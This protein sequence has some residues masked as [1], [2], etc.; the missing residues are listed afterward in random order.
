M[1]TLRDLLRRARAKL[2]KATCSALA[3]VTT[4]LSGHILATIIAG[5]VRAPHEFCSARVNSRVVRAVS[6]I[7]LAKPSVPQRSE[8]QLEERHGSN[9]SQSRPPTLRPPAAGGLGAF[10]DPGR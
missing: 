1:R 7:R 4:S 2:D 8:R 9:C 5:L 10:V 3:R 6:W